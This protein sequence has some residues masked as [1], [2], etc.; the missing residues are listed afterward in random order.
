[1]WESEVETIIEESGSL[2]DLLLED[3]IIFDV[4]EE[5]SD[6]VIELYRTN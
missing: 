6:I 4:M 3:E 1:M 5:E 2:E